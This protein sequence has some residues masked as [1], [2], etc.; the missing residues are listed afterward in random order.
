M[1]RQ[2][3]QLKFILEKSMQK[4]VASHQKGKVSGEMPA[5]LQGMRLLGILAMALGFS[6]CSASLQTKVSGNLDKL[7]PAQTIAILPVE[8]QND[9][10]MEMARMFRQNLHAHLQESNFNLLEHYIVDSQLKR[11]GLI[12]PAQYPKL[13]PVNFGEILGVDAVLMSRVNKLRKSYF[14]IHS[15][16][17]VSVSVQLIDTRTGEIL[18]QA[19]QTESDFEGIAKIPTGIAA[20]VYAPINLVAST[21]KLN[22]MTSQMVGRLTSVLKD[23]SAAGEEKT[24]EKPRIAAAWTRGAEEGDSQ[25]HWTQVAG[26]DASGEAG[27]ASG[28]GQEVLKKSLQDQIPSAILEKEL[29]PVSK[30]IAAKKP[31]L[32]ETQPQT[33]PAAGQAATPSISF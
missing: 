31:P 17:E 10:Q 28:Q 33:I 30:R 22:E 5:F 27:S 19:E 2:R 26:A 7:S 16:I 12:D 24:F 21:L 25:I 1:T 4:S 11:N 6:A 18:W 29:V 20:A 8:V 15:S 9:G 14:L 32:L 23:P 3:E 13:D